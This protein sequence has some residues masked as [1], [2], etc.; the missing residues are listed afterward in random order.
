MVKTVYL[1][2]KVKVE[3]PE[4]FT[5]DACD[6]VGEECD[7]DVKLDREDLKI[8]ATEIVSSSPEFSKT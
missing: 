6:V 3:V 1:T 2:I 5:G 7:Y 4:N 8:V